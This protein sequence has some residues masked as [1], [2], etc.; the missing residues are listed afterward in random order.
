MNQSSE[1]VK[2]SICLVFIWR[3]DENE[4]IIWGIGEIYIPTAQWV[5]T[6]GDDDKIKI[7]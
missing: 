5:Q 7:P 2:K 3:T 6:K 1:Y 4:G